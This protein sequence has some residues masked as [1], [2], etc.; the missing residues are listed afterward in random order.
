MAL[1]ER[2]VQVCTDVAVIGA[3]PA[4]M[5]AALVLARAGRKVILIEREPFIG[6]LAV[7]LE[8]LFPHLECSPCLLE[9]L[10]GDILH[11]SVNI[12]LLTLSGWAFTPTVLYL[13]MSL[14]QRR[15]NFQ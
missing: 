5:Q 15:A 2:L 4:G 8:E 11:G 10:M 3:G 12:T 13:T 9:P 7:Q 1:H 6:G 14:P